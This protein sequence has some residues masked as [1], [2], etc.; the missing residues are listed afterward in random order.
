M[1]NIGIIGIGLMG[2][3]LAKAF[4][5]LEKIEQIIAFDKNQES[6]EKAKIEG[7]VTKVT[8]QIGDDF[9]NLDFIFICTP[10]DSIY[11]YAEKLKY[12]VNENCIIS[13]IGSTKKNIVQKIDALNLNFVGTHPMIGSEKY[14]YDFSS[15]DLFADSYYIIT[16]TDKTKREDIDKIKELIK[17]INAIPLEIDLDKH[18]FA[19]GVI[20]H[21]PHIVA[22]G[23]VNLVEKLDDENQTIKTIA[24]GGFKDITRIASANSNMWQ[25]ICKQNKE[26]IIVILDEFKEII[27]NFK[28]NINSTE[29]RYEYF[30]N[31]KKY[32][33]SFI[34]KNK[35]DYVTIEVKNKAGVLA[36]ITTICANNS[37]NIRNINVLRTKEKEDGIIKI[38][39]ENEGDKQKSIKLL[40]EHKYEVS[41]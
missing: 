5:K 20:S 41:T 21:V 39:F 22:S 10:V 13:D 14:G 38:L 23:L 19:V 6:L 36:D 35:V 2:G 33:D 24:A 16:K 15:E 32:R 1:Y 28:N 3:S 37:I 30:D 34:T 26:E 17:M 9:K 27:E 8:N 40:K 29:K 31:A 18:D 7:Y 12:I 25:S 11:E 4:S